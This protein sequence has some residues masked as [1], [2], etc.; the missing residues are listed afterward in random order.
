[1]KFK[2][3]VSENIIIFPKINKK[4]GFAKSKSSSS[5]KY[6]YLCTQYLVG[7]PLAQM[8]ASARCGMEAISLWHC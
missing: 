5:L 7:A 8:A 1:M 2:N 6:V 4:K 3:P